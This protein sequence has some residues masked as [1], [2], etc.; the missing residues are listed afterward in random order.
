M[1]EENNPTIKWHGN[2]PFAEK[3][4]DIYYSMANGLAESRH[5]FVDGNNLAERFANLPEH[6][7]FHI[8]ELG[9]GT[10]LNFFT[11]WQ[12]FIEYAPKTAQ[13]TFTSLEKYPLDLQMWR[14]ALAVWPELNSEVLRLQP[15]YRPKNRQLTVWR[16]APNVTLKIYWQDVTEALNGWK[17]PCDAWF[18]DGFNPAT[19]PQMWAKET[20][21]RVFELTKPGGTAATFAVARLVRESMRFAGFSLKK[22]PGYGTKREML[23]AARN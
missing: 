15:L 14:G 16:P 20:C 2:Q 9:F 22:R 18:L 8:G 19:N 17:Q 7:H 3:F 11:A 5:V 1:I 12:C 6:G 4:D 13:L 21:S 10:G 23:T